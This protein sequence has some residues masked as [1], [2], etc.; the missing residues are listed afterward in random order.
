MKESIL[1]KFETQTF[2]FCLLFSS[3]QIFYHQN[4]HLLIMTLIQYHTLNCEI[5]I[6]IDSFFTLNKNIYLLASEWLTS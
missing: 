1:C 4:C 5:N 3:H 2:F 6:V